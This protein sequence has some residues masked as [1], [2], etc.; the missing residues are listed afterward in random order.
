MV[1]EWFR[2]LYNARSFVPRGPFL[3]YTS[4]FLDTDELKKAL[5]ALKVSGAF[6]KRAPSLFSHS[7]PWV[8]KKRVGSLMEGNTLFWVCGNTYLPE[9]LLKRMFKSSDQLVVIDDL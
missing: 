9:T 7:R 5:R 6:E 3:V 4:Q 1:S 2:N 8:K